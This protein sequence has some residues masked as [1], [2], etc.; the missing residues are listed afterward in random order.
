MGIVNI[1]VIFGDEI[2]GAVDLLSSRTVKYRFDINPRSE[3]LLE[4]GARSSRDVAV[5]GVLPSHL[6]LLSVTVSS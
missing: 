5:F 4:P 3:I 2:P 6:I 1:T